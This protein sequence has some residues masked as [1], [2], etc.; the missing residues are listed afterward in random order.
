MSWSLFD[1][2]SGETIP[3]GT[4]L[5]TTEGYP[6][7]YDDF[8]QHHIP[9]GTVVQPGDNS[10][11]ERY[12]TEWQASADRH[13]QRL[14]K[15]QHTTHDD[16]YILVRDFR[17]AGSDAGFQYN[18]QPVAFFA[19]Y[20]HA[21]GGYA[22]EAVRLL[23]SLMQTILVWTDSGCNDWYRRIY[24]DRVYEDV[25]NE[26]IT[27]IR[28]TLDRCESLA[29]SVRART[30]RVPSTIWTTF[31]ETDAPA[32]IETHQLFVSSMAPCFL[33]VD[34]AAA[35]SA[36][37][38]ELLLKVTELKT[39]GWRARKNIDPLSEI[40]R[41]CEDNVKDIERTYWAL[42]RAKVEQEVKP[43]DPRHAAEVW[44]ASTK[45]LCE[46]VQSLSGGNTAVI[47][48]AIEEHVRFLIRR[49]VQP[50]I[51]SHGTV[52]ELSPS[53]QID[54]IIW[55]PQAAP[56]LLREGDLVVLSAQSVKGLMEIKTSVSSYWDLHERMTS[57]NVQIDVA[58][59]RDR[60]RRRPPSL[61]VIAMDENDWMEIGE[62]TRWSAIALFRKTNQGLVANLKCWEVLFEFIHRHVCQQRY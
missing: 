26:M 46:R 17:P 62:L 8:Q 2:H 56:A 23:R 29:S 13:E 24:K 18:G 47:G 14:L 12:R 15:L 54:C 37:S 60:H 1:E 3:L 11:F 36:K 57:I 50:Y 6:I 28:T 7:S 31:C 21:T 51:V 10:A 19:M 39:A 20:R 38:T 58:W 30:S 22:V 5:R 55:D 16:Q 41:V 53:P 40:L 43:A 25:S 27:K 33:R 35:M 48:A 42:Y 59:S 32:L 9:Y 61:T 49:S 4:D 34:E 44:S 52:A 45:V